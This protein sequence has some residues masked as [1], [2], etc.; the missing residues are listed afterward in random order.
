VT[1]LAS[2]IERLIAIA[3]IFSGRWFRFVLLA[4]C[5][6]PVLR[7]FNF[8]SQPRYNTK[9]A[10]LADNCDA[11]YDKYWMC[12]SHCLD[13]FRV[14]GCSSCCSWAGYFLSWVSAR[15]RYSATLSETFTICSFVFFELVSM[16]KS[17]KI[18]ERV[19]SSQGWVRMG[20]R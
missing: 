15:P 18:V 19:P 6:V 17:A 4:S 1:L 16:L 2:D 5:I 13:F 11:S 14:A 8:F 9:L 7:V 3:L 20:H 10:R 12:D